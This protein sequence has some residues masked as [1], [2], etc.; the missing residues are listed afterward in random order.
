MKYNELMNQIKVTPQM[1][2][3][4]L[5]A[6]AADQKRRRAR[7]LYRRVAALAACLAV[8]A[9]AWTF[10]SRRLPAAPPEEMVSSAYGIIEYASVEELS[11]AL[12]FTVKTPGELPFAPEEVSHDAWF[13]D[14][15]EI[16]Y[17]GAE[18]LL[19]TRMA[20][21]AED[22]SG[23]YNVY[24]QVETVPLA[25]ATVTLKGENDRVSLAVWT[26]GEY[27]FSV[28]VEPA[29]SQEEMLRVIESFRVYLKKEEATAR[30]DFSSVQGGKSKV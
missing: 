17:R 2:R 5:D 1:R 18:A 14:L 8:A 6:I 15:A 28:S 9:G 3:R 19:T 22:P 26:D 4:V 13:G 30:A 12:G 20:A 24:R 10:A 29:I 16:N 21:G 27:A 7:L 25:D 11:R 23:D